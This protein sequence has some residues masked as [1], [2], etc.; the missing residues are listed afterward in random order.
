M[1]GN[2][3]LARA[4]AGCPL[5]G[6]LREE[7]FAVDVCDA[8]TPVVET[9]R[10]GEYALLILDPAFPGA[11]GLEGCRRVRGESDV[12]IVIVTARDSE[13]DRVLGLEA[14]A[15]DYVGEPFS[16][17]ELVSRVRAILR[18][19]RLDLEPRLV[20][21]V[22]DLEL[23]FASHQ[24]SRDGRPL[25]LTP[26]EFRLLAYLSS[27]PGRAFSRRDILRHL[28]RS[29]YVGDDGACKAHISNLRQKLEADPAHPSHVVTVRGVGYALRT[30]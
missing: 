11:G 21:R 6:A 22:G 17:P 25:P 15:D 1:S 27:E 9:A 14:G 4:T 18:R 26:S 7:G 5:A 28:W 23:D 3:L 8:G 2:V 16:L 30:A 10:A 20:R 24:A 29:D 19:R 12:P 13:A